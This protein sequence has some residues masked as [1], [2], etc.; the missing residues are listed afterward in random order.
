MGLA[1]D[2]PLEDDEEISVDGIEIRVERRAAPFAAQS[3]ID[4][5]DSMWGRGFS[6]RPTYGGGC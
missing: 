3:L 4:F 5:V 6:I 1:L 2:E